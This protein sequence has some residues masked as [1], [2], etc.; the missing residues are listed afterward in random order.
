M[1][2][3]VEH[4]QDN[5]Y[6]VFDLFDRSELEDKLISDIEDRRQESCEYPIYQGSLSNCEAFIRL[7]Q[8]ENVQF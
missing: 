4:L 8:N 6:Q 2:Y 1:D 3:R 5:T 7:K